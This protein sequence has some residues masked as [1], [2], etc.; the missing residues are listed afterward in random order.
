MVDAPI[1]SDELS[2]LIGAIY[3][4]ALDPSRWE[5]TL[6]ELRQAFEGLTGVLYLHDVRGRRMMI[7]RTVGMAPAW[8]KLLDEHTP[9]VSTRLMRDLAS[10]PSLDQPHL[11]SRH[12]PPADAAQSPY[13]QQCLKPNGICDIINYFLMHTPTRFAGFAI[14]RHERHGIFTERELKLGSLLLPH[15]RRAV[16]ISNVLDASTIERER[17]TELLNG[18]RCAVLLTDERGKILHANRFAEN[19]LR[20]GI[21]I[22]RVN[23]LLRTKNPAAR[24]EMHAA[25][26]TAARDEVSIGATGLAIC[27]TEPGS[28]SVFAHVLPMTGGELRAGL[29]PMAVASVF[30]GAIPDGQDG[31]SAMAVTYGLTPAETRVAASLLAGHTLAQTARSLRIAPSTA[32]T[33]LDKVFLKTGVARQADLIRL[34]MQLVPPTL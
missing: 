34:G 16:T 6:D 13:I 5:H 25:I 3:D 4:C 26:R 2:R 33:H 17:M 31:A 30:I 24:A 12:I 20:N 10:F 19:M 7:N 15:L 14:G 27:L 28:T 18:L 11:M 1:P 23:G 22:E 8:L 21:L 29:Q 9:E 32:K